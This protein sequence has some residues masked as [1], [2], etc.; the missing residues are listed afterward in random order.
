MA[1]L[2]ISIAGAVPAVLMTC[3]KWLLR[4]RRVAGDKRVQAVDSL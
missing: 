2:V 3:L 1:A 4:L